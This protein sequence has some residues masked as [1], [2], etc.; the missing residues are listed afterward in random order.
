MSTEAAEVVQEDVQEQEVFTYELTD[1][2]KSAVKAI[3]LATHKDKAEDE[4]TEIISAAETARQEELKKEYAPVF[5]KAAELKALPEN[6]EKTEDELIALAQESIAAA[7]PK[8]TDT[9]DIN[10]D[11]E[12]MGRAA[13]GTPADNPAA[14]AAPAVELPA[15][16]KEKIAK[17]EKIESDPVMVAYL[18]AKESN[19]DFDLVEMVAQS[20][21]AYDPAKASYME[22]KR[23]E[24]KEA[25]KEDTNITDEQ[26]EDEL[27]EFAE[28]TPIR[29]REEVKATRDHLIAHYK[30]AKSKFAVQVAKQVDSS[31]ETF[32]QTVREA[33]SELKTYEGQRYRGAEV[34]K[35]HTDKVLSAIRSGAVPFKKADGTPDVSKSVEVLLAYELQSETQNAAYERGKRD[36]E[37]K[38]NAT[39]SKPL[40]IR[41]RSA[42]TPARST[43][44]RDA[45]N[46]EKERMLK[47]MDLA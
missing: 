38:F 34:S 25:Q 11:P 31:K 26:I 33:E 18:Q 37:R 39:K 45:F 10:N 2:E 46:K 15:E 27:A 19:A 43:N 4:L 16:V 23:W 20:G 3:V 42:A 14:A 28:K 1:E 17:Y 47:Q 35:A 36:A 41:A 29:Q 8:G 44:S 6:A 7:D 5:A 30:E 32:V 40:P 22:I 13:K 21:L 24:L 9:Y 12:F